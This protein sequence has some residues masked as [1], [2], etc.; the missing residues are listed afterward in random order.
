MKQKI[1]DIFKNRNIWFF[2]IVTILF[3]GV[4]VRVE[5]ATDTYAVFNFSARA[6]FE[7][8]ASSGRFVTAII[9]TIL[10]LLNIKNETMYIYSFILAIICMIISQYKLYKIIKFD[11]KN[12]ILNKIIPILIVLNAFSIELFLFIEKG[13]MV[14]AVLMC[15]LALENII[16]SFE[17]K[18]KKY[19]IYATIYMLI[20]NCSYQGVVGIFVAISLIYILKYSKSIK[21]FF[22]NNIVVALV[23]GIPAI[24]DYIVVKILYSSSRINGKIILSES[25]EKI[26]LSTID[27]IKSTYNL[28][29]KYFF[30]VLVGITIFILIYKIITDKK[31]N[32]N[33]F[34]DFGKM[35]YILAGTIV[36]TIAP[37]LMQS[38]D[39]IWFVSRSTYAFASLYGILI[40]YLFMNYEV[41]KWIRNIVIT[42]SLALLIVQLY[43]FNII[44]IDR[45]KMNAIDCEI[46]QKICEEINKYERKTG[47]Q[48]TKIAIYQDSLPGY[49]YK[50]IF[51][52]GDINIKAYSADWSTIFI[53]NYYSGKNLKGIDID[54]KTAEEFNKN[55]W[56]NFDKEQLVFEGDTLHLCRY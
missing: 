45:Y 15:I 31:L 52:T 24:I 21:E 4:L 7:Q 20:A 22:I 48:I 17:E 43:K 12:N 30:L 25:L 6:L 1:K 54:S 19:I 41:D 11:V 53:I 13:I 46:T 2:S 40:L 38:T 26:Y 3:F 55:N 16:K 5:F 10:K 9:G 47:N 18:K 23:Y 32:K 37:Q 44:E 50:G 33:K 51:A 34:V 28:L 56:D 35:I 36:V 27:M 49:T 8:F 42:L 29:P 39:Q 14:M